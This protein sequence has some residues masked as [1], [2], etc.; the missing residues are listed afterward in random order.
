MAIV[1][2]GVVLLLLDILFTCV[3]SALGFSYLYLLY[4][5]MMYVM[6]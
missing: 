6:I 5:D 1:Q 2:D 4:D 3:F